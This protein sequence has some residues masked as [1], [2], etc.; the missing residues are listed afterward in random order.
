[1][2]ES[3]SVMT[4][5][6]GIWTL[7]AACMVIASS[8]I[9]AESLKDPTRPPAELTRAVADSGSAAANAAAPVLQSVLISPGRTVAIISGQA[10]R[11][12]ER[13]GDARVVR[14]TEREVTLRSGKDVQT[15]KLFPNIEKK[16]S[17]VRAS[18]KSY[19]RAQ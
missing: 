3:V 6:N 16:P 18:V 11:L 2:A 15:L 1:M 12:G 13:Y 7:S 4:M 10:V 19:S 9:K 5:R 14:I 8:A 17:D